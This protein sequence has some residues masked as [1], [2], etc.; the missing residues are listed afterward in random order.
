MPAGEGIGGRLGGGKALGAD[1]PEGDLR[2]NERGKVAKRQAKLHDG[3]TGGGGERGGRDVVRGSRDRGWDMLAKQR[4]E[5]LAALVGETGRV[6]DM[7]TQGAPGE[8]CAAALPAHAQ[9]QLAGRAATPLEAG[10]GLGSQ[11][12]K[13]G[14][15]VLG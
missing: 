14:E 12:R 5:E 3:I 13:E 6:V 7:G 9:A 10:G 4:G 8:A 2:G 15:G 11:A 1:A